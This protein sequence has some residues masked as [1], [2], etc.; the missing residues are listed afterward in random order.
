MTVSYVGNTAGTVTTGSSISV[1]RSHTAGNASVFVV[2]TEGV[3]TGVVFDGVDKAVQVKSISSTKRIYIYAVFNVAS[4][5][6][7]WIATLSGSARIQASITEA[8]GAYSVG[9][10]TTYTSVSSWGWSLTFNPLS[11]DYL[12]IGADSWEYGH[13]LH[14]ITSGTAIYDTTY[15][16]SLGYSLAYKQGT[17]GS[18]SISMTSAQATPVDAAAIWLS[19]ALSGDLLTPIWLD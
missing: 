5:N 13:A 9:G 6:H 18:T 14:S 12:E 11:A 15:D 10:T 8:S 2:H 1:T 4:G 3:V 19:T 17:G 16:E 7:T